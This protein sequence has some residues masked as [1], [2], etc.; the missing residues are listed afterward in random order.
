[1]TRIRIDKHLT[2]RDIYITGHCRNGKDSAAEPILIC[3]A[4]TALAQTAA[5]NVY[6]SEDKGEADIIDIT[7]KSGQAVISYITDNDTLNAVVDGICRGFFM[8]AENYPE[9]IEYIER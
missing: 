2:G 1:M 9:Y 3:E 5:C 4:V 8:L 6:D 7:L